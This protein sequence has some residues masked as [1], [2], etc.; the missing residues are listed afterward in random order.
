MEAL[1]QLTGG[2]AHDFNNLLMV[3]SGHAQS[4]LRRLT[5]P[6]DVRALEAIQAAASRGEALTRQLLTF[7][8]RQPLNPKTVDLG[9][10][11]RRRSATCWRARRAAIS[12][13]KSISRRTSGRSPIDIPE[14]ELALVNLVV[15]ARDAMPDGGTITH[16]G[17][18]YRA[19]RR[20]DR[21]N[22]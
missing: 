12:S 3:V 14:F 21:R 17:G 4:L 7:S 18:K 15:N 16:V 9:A 10:D 5:D 6:K 19:G 2:V 1:G 13:C 11:R 8:R 22:S 20:G